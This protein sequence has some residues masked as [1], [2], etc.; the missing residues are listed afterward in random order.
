[1]GWG[2]KSKNASNSVRKMG[3]LQFVELVQILET[4][5]AIN[6]THLW[7]SDNYVDCIDRIEGLGISAMA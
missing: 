4:G 6:K 3:N 1:M 7:Q 2:M 5:V